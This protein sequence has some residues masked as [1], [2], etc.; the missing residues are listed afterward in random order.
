MIFLFFSFS[1]GSAA[2]GWGNSVRV[3]FFVGRGKRYIPV[4]FSL[5]CL[6][7]LAGFGG[8]GLIAEGM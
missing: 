5:T 8:G 3:S 7:F 2:F 1:F 6:R 4:L